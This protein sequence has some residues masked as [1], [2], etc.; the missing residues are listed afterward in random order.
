MIPTQA[1]AQL[2]KTRSVLPFKAVL[3][4]LDGTLV[5]FKFK[6]KESRLALIELLKKKGFD[7]RSWTETTRTQRII[8]D[9]ETQWRNS[10]NLREGQDFD[11]V[12]RELYRLLDDFEYDALLCAKPHAGSI[13]ILRKLKDAQLMSGIVTNSGRGPVEMM[14]R[15]SGFLSYLSVLVTRN[16]MKRMKPDPSG[17]LEAMK[18]LEVKHE[19]TLYVGDSVIDI[20]AARAAK[21]KCASVATGLYRADILREHSPDYLI[22]AIEELEKIALSPARGK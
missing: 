15:E 1:S 20:E 16:E 17:L 2:S 22:D 7:D 3:F 6:V 9:A 4:D 5:E 13:Y 14:L 19:E 18:K 11:S 12:R 21:I 8:D 10:E